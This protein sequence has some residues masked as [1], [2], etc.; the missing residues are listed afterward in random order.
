MA[1]DKDDMK[2]VRDDAQ[3]GNCATARSLSRRTLLKGAA[4]A[5][6]I[7]RFPAVNAAGSRTLRIGCVAAISGPGALFGGPM[8]F[9]KEQLEK[10][11]R[12]GLNIGGKRYSVEIILRD[13]QS[14]INVATQVT[15][16]LMTRD[17]VDL[18]VAPEGLA[19]IGAGQ[20]A[21]VNRVPLVSTLFPADAMIGLRGGPDAYSN[22]GKPWTFHFLFETPDVGDAYLGM[23]KP[24]RHK[25]NEIVGTFYLDQPAARGFADPQRGLPATLKKGEYKTVEAGMFKI[26][27]DDF[28]NQVSTFKNA[29]AQIL[30]GFMFANH[31]ASFWRGAAQAS[32][33]PQIVTIPGAFL[34][35]GGVDALGDRGDGMSTEI[36]WSP[37]LPYAS[38]L[39]GQSAQQLADAWEASKGEQWTPSLGYTHAI[40]EVAVHAL[41]ASG[42]PK[43]REA[44]RASLAKTAVDTVI[45]KIDFTKGPVPGIATTA[46]VAGQWRRAKKGK[47]KY[48]LLVTYASPSSAFKVEDE[49]KLLSELG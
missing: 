19:A 28:S 31:F 27:T 21:V 15:T 18:V 5:A 29:G 22:K 6:M 37:K 38:S 26:E 16:E 7:L 8:G 49:F 42:D 17:K 12:G 13:S 35:P 9:V 4:A 1:R 32:Y 23:W 3:G 43:N 20:M 47:Y 36:W 10:I 24:V 44:V 25:T 33:K 30:T 11:F 2:S 41:K 46:L 40:W 48:D 14:S 34:F 45:G 39:T